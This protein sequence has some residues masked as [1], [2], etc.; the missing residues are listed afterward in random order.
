MTWTFHPTPIP[1]TAFPVECA[2]YLV[3]MSVLHLAAFILG[4]ICLAVLSLRQPEL[5]WERIGRLGLFLGLFLIFGAVFNGF[6]SC[7]VWSRFYD[8]TDYVFDFVP[9][10]PITQRT[11]DRPWGNQHGQLLG[12]S[13]LQLQL[14]WAAFAASTWGITIYFYRRICKRRRQSIADENTA[15]LNF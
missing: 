12:V 4:S 6:W 2:W 14:V 5:I 11:L 15:A 8:S 10:W 7:L 3:P 1:W 9:F 13:L